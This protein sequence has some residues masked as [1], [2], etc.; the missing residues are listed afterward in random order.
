MMNEQTKNTSSID[1]YEIHTSSSKPL[2]NK[3]GSAMAQSSMRFDKV[4]R[5]TI[6]LM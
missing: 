1:K 3:N 5:S 2:P 6:N 4:L